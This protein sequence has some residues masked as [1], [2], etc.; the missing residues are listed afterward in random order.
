[1]GLMER[2]TRMIARTSVALATIWALL[3][4]GFL[5]QVNAQAPQDDGKPGKDKDTLAKKDD[6]SAKQPVKLGLAIN[7]PRAFQGS[8]LLAPMSS[9]STYLL[10]MAGHIVHAWDSD[11]SPALCPLLLGNGHLLR[12]GSI[13]AEAQPFGPGPGVGGRIQE[14]TWEGELVWDFR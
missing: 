9:T 4:L 12:P 2:R 13:G 8:T 5:S 3:A 1:H 6:K 14:F 11:C 10:A 7:D